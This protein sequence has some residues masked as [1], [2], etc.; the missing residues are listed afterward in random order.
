MQ[1]II[2]TVQQLIT[3]DIPFLLSIGTLVKAIIVL[4]KNICAKVHYYEIRNILLMCILYLLI[5]QTGCVR[6][7]YYNFNQKISTF[8]FYLWI[9]IDVIIQLVLFMFIHALDNIMTIFNGDKSCSK[10]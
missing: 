7:A 4:K 9:V 3:T 2:S 6:W 1:R 5:Y 8:D 10:E